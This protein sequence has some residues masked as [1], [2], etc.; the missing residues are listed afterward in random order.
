MRGE[1]KKGKKGNSK[2]KRWAG[3]KQDKN[4]NIDCKMCRGSVRRWDLK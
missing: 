2:G 3:E 4:I 1:E